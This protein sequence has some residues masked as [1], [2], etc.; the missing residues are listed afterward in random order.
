MQYRT[1]PS[2]EEVARVLE[3]NEMIETISEKLVR[4]GGRMSRYGPLDDHIYFDLKNNTG[5][6]PGA[7]IKVFVAS[8]T[9]NQHTL[10][11][12]QVEEVVGALRYEIAA[13]YD[14]FE[15]K[16]FYRLKTPFVS[17]HTDKSNNKL[18]VATI[19]INAT[20]VVWPRNTVKIL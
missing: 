17:I 19:Q 1:T 13:W 7:S 8:V 5:T 16:D 9:N 20:A 3:T 18:M 6:P 12:W 15:I 2:S 4:C 11:E 14:L 10:Y